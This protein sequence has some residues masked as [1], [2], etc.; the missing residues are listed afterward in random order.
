MAEKRI[1]VNVKT[2]TGYD[3]LYPDSKA[4]YIA[5]DNQVSEVDPTDVQDALDLTFDTLE[6]LNNTV[7]GHTSSLDN[8]ATELQTT[9]TNLSNLSNTFNTAWGTIQNST[10]IVN[11]TTVSVSAW[12]SDSTV[13][14]P[15]KA[16]VAVSGATTSYVADV[17]F[18]LADASGGN[19]APTCETGTNTVTIRAMEKPS[20]TITIPTIKLIKVVQ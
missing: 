9:N 16:N 10:I 5:Y 8:F 2:S 11:N 20:T 14:Y 19:F 1:E 4:S 6:N 15:W 7:S 12:S 3:Q 18:S 17:Y 13:D